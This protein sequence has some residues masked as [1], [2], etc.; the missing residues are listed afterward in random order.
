[1]F[2]CQG[3]GRRALLPSQD[4]AFILLP[5]LWTGTREGSP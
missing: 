1:M 2:L 3:R 4:K 5:I